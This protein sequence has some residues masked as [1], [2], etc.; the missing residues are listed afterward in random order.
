M[1]HLYLAMLTVFALMASMATYAGKVYK[2]QDDDGSWHYSENPP[3]E[4]EAETLKIK[5]S[6]KNLEQT[7]SKN[8]DSSEK[9]I[10]DKE[11]V[12]IKP[13]TNTETA[14]TPEEIKA[15]CNLATKRLSG[16]ESHPRVLITDEKTGDK[17]YLSPDEHT[18][19]MSKSRKEINEFCTEY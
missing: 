7:D 3:Y 6:P 2:W 13:K 17:R 16:L 5:T 9:N 19:W 8:N 14:Y 18:E 4:K 12:E 11:S 15:N 1:K 10:G